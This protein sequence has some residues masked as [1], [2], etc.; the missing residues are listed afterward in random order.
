MRQM[1]FLFKFE[2]NFKFLLSTISARFFTSTNP[3]FF[4]N[5]N[6]SP[7]SNLEPN[8]GRSLCVM[9]MGYNIV[10]LLIDLYH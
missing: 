1:I 4:C 2:L 8:F 10:P 7:N 9:N 3:N 5:P 6:F